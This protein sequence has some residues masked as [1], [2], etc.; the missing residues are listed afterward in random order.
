[1]K[2]VWMGE[3]FVDSSFVHLPLPLGYDGTANNHFLLL[4]NQSFK[5]NA[6]K[7]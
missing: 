6:L 2:H 1:M 7:H 3:I 4:E 5:L